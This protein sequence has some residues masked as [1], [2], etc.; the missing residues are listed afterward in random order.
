MAKV[1]NRF[2]F[3]IAMGRIGS[4]LVVFFMPL[5]LT[6]F[7]SQ[8]DYGIFSQFFTLYST[9]YVI[10]GLGLQTSLFYFYPTASKQEKSAYMSNTMLMLLSM[11][12]VAFLL[13]NIPVVKNTLFGNGDLSEYRDY[14]IICI[15]L[16]IP[17]NAVGPSFT[18][19]ENKLGALLIPGTV[20]L[21]RVTVIIFTVLFAGSLRSVFQTLVFFQVAVLIFVLFYTMRG[22]KITV[23]KTLMKAQ[24]A[25]SLP[26]GL[27]VALQLFS[28]YF[29]KIVSIHYLTTVDYAIYSVAFLSIPGINQIYDSLCQV[30]IIN[31][32]RCY[33]EGEPEQI[34]PLYK[35]FVI[36]TLS[37]SAPVILIVALFAD[38]IIAF[39]YPLSYNGAAI[40]FRLYTLTFLVA[41]L[42]AGTI[43]RSVNKTP[44]SLKAFLISCAIGLPLTFLLVSHF[45]IKGAIAGA[46]INIMLP[47]IIQMLFEMSIMHC[48]LRQYLPW[49]AIVRIFMISIV[50]IL[51]FGL[52]KLL[53][54]MNIVVY[55]LFAGVYI[56]FCYS[57][58][59]KYNVFMLSKTQVKSM[60]ETAKERIMRRH[61]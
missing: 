4:M 3:W 51:P 53:P 26:F 52:V 12:A 56:V 47:R 21:I 9:L 6:R 13:L 35:D 59:L 41:M 31:M 57:Q 14:A 29:D 42:G 17:M 33:Q 50:W 1:S 37:F 10:F 19:R 18:V 39:L 34:V 49:K 28:N 61:E 48:T 36:K 20:A 45:G 32:T 7:L 60:Y 38:E 15:S 2:A 46:I 5:L 58:M 43:L 11:S 23:N 8:S 40:Y 25:Y 27:T 16:A 22:E 44:M 24:L 30:N 55:M 54:R